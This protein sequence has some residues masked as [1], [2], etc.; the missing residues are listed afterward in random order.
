MN[1]LRRDFS[2][3]GKSSFHRGERD[4][5]LN[6]LLTEN[7]IILLYSTFSWLYDRINTRSYSPIKCPPSDA[8]ERAKE[9]LAEIES[10]PDDMDPDVQELRDIL[11]DPHF[12]DDTV[13]NVENRICPNKSKFSCEVNLWSL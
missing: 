3:R 1:Q 7:S 5:E 11:C 12:R 6:R 8:L 10:W 2:Y 9:V 4:E 13:V